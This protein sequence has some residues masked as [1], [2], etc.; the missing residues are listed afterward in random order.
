MEHLNSDKATVSV[1]PDVVQ[2]L[3]NKLCPL[4]NVDCRD[5]MNNNFDGIVTVG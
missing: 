4:L 1:F 5:V 2:S 3:V